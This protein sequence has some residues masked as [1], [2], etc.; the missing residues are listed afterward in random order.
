MYITNNLFNTTSR[1]YMLKL[2]PKIK[3]LRNS[4]IIGNI[5]IYRKRKFIYLYIYKM[6]KINIFHA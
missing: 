4:K 3:M 6:I 1:G 5:H 2:P